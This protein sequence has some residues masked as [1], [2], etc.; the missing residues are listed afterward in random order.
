MILIEWSCKECGYIWYEDHL[1]NDNAPNYC[2]ACSSD[3]LP[4]VNRTGKSV[5]GE[6]ITNGDVPTD[7]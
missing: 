2:P 6:V 4:E 5:S 1:A 7:R 3:V